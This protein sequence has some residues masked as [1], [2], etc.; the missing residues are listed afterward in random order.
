M[1]LADCKNNQTVTVK[2]ILPAEGMGKLFEYGFTI[3]LK[4]K[5]IRKAAFNGPIFIATD[6]VKLAI[7]NQQAINII[8]E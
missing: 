3:G 5:I 4:V 8:V 6:T 7:R 2:E 1:N